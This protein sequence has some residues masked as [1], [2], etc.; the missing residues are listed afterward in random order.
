L[1]TSKVLLTKTEDFSFVGLTCQGF[2]TSIDQC[3]FNKARNCSTSEAAT[4]VCDT[5]DCKSKLFLELFWKQ[6]KDTSRNWIKV[7]HVY[8]IATTFGTWKWES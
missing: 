3:Y 6:C 2:E 7:T 8:S 1:S 5:K 4:V